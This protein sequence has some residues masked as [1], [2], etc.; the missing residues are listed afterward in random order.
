ML[1]IYGTCG[2]PMHVKEVFKKDLELGTNT[3]C[4][5]RRI[6]FDFQRDTRYTKG[7]YKIKRSFDCRC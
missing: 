2:L 1:V 7:D 3:K 4:A 5:S 6:K